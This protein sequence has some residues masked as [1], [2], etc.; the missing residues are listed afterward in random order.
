MHEN[1]EKW[2]VGITLY[3][4]MGINEISGK[5]SLNV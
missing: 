1:E 2:Q 4:Q 3:I 5:W